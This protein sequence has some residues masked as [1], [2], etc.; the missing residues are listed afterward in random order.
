M[1]YLLVILAILFQPKL[2]ISQKQESSLR[3]K[4]LPF[5][6]LMFECEVSSFVE[7]SMHCSSQGG[8]KIGQQILKVQELIIMIVLNVFGTLYKDKISDGNSLCIYHYD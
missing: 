3:L 2:F 4:G 6:H 5:I 1:F 8:C 7:G